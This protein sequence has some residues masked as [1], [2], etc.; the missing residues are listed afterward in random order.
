MVSNI[1]GYAILTVA[2]KAS[3]ASLESEQAEVASR[4]CLPYN[5]SELTNT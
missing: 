1:S 5:H 4:S 2:A 3:F